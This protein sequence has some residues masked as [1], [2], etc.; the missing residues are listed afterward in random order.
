M[1]TYMAQNIPAIEQG[2]KV[3]PKMADVHL[4]GDIGWGHIDADLF[5]GADAG[6]SHA[7]TE[8]FRHLVG[9][10]LLLQ[11]DVD[12]TWS[13][14]LHLKCITRQSQN[15]CNY[16]RTGKLCECD[17]FMYSRTW[18]TLALAHV[19]YWVDS[20]A[21]RHQRWWRIGH[22][23]SEFLLIILVTCKYH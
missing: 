7:L 11:V 23:K 15:H 2:L 18:I 22:M 1:W 17:N 3:L 6:G 5:L 20:Y 14:N 9:D 21:F 12:E 8:Q 10:K 16:C 4:L 19:I 13:R